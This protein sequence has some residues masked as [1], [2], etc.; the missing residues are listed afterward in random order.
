VEDNV[1]TSREQFG[2]APINTIISANKLD[3]DLNNM[4]AQEE[5]DGPII[6]EI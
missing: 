3:S 6:S 2:K 4:S 1:Y 5:E